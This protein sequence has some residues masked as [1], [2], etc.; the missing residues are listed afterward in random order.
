MGYKTTRGD[1][2]K[3]YFRKLK[4]KG[5]IEMSMQTI[6][7]VVIGITLLTLGLQFVYKTFADVGSQQK[8][9]NEATQKQLREL[10]GESDDP[11]ALISNSIT[12]KQG[13]SEDF[14]VGFKNI[15]TTGGDFSYKVILDSAPNN[16]KSVDWMSSQSNDLGPLG[17][18]DDYPELLALDVPNDAIP[19]TYRFKI[20]LTC[21]ADGCGTGKKFPFTIRVTA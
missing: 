14:A 18:G 5:A 7:V 17:V 13:A 2:M 6:I 9:V 1:C 10:F 12:I 20:E 16:L 11:V 4:K 19:G 15:G 8:A 3:S 21:S